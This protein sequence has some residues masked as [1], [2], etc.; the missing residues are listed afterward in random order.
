[1]LTPELFI[2]R[3]FAAFAASVQRRESFDASSS[4]GGMTAAARTKP[5]II[6]GPSQ[7]LPSIIGAG[8]AGPERHDAPPYNRGKTRPFHA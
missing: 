2:R 1:L 7:A 3:N 5:S 6:A 4:R 8:F